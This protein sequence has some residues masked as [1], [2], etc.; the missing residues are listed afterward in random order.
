[1]AV[2]VGVGV[3]HGRPL[4][5]SQLGVGVGHGGPLST[6]TVLTVVFAVLKPS[7]TSTRPSGSLPCACPARLPIIGGPARN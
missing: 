2:A 7:A 1:M 5:T 6:S 3:R 4:R